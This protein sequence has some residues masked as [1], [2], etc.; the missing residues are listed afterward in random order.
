MAT[1]GLG[2]SPCRLAEPVSLQRNAS[3]ATKT[4]SPRTVV[5]L[6]VSLPLSS[7]S[8][9]SPVAV[10]VLARLTSEQLSQE[11]PHIDR[12][13]L[14]QPVSASTLSGHVLGTVT[15]Q[16][17]PVQTLISG[18]HHETNQFPCP[19]VLPHPSLSGFPLVP[20]S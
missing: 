20:F 1:Q 3:V 9:G 8:L 7:K 11:L 14:P 5:R 4:T 17:R 19:E 16:T 2:Q 10:E 18:K 6:V 12:I 13:P 15:R